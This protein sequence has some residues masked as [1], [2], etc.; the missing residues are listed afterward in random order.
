MAETLLELVNVSKFYTGAQSVV[1]GLNSVSLSFSRGEFVAITGESGSGKTTLASVV[2][3]ILPY[4]SGELFFK[5]KPTSHYGSL[6]WERYRRDNIAY[7]SQNYGILP[8]ASVSKNV[9]SA[10]VI[11]GMKKSD[12]KRAAKDILRRVDLLSLKNR[13]AA[14][15]SS[16][17]KQRL[18]IA[19]A[20]AK[21]APILIADEP[22]GNLD[23]ENSAKIIELLADAAKDRLVILVTHEFDEAKDLATRHI[24]VSEGRIS[25]DTQLKPAPAPGPAPTVEAKGKKAL[26]FYVARLQCSSRPVWTAM[27]S[28]FFAVTAFAVFAFL[29]VFISSIDDT[30]TRI[31]DSSA[32]RNG[33][34]TRIVVLGA[35]SGRLDEDDYRAFLSI[36]HVE[37]VEPWGNAADAQYGY[38]E[39]EG[40]YVSYSEQTVKD[41]ETWEDVQIVVSTTHMYENAPFVRTI[42]I[43][44][45][46]V[47]FLTDG[48]LPENMYEVVSGDKNLKIGDVITIYLVDDKTMNGRGTKYFRSK[49]KVVGLTDY[50]D[51]LFFHDDV[52]RFLRQTYAMTN[53]MDKD[54]GFVY[55]PNNE[56][57]NEVSEDDPDY[58]LFPSPQVADGHFVGSWNTFNSLI[59]EQHFAKSEEDLVPFR[60]RSDD[61]DE[62]AEYREAELTP[63]GEY[64]E[65]EGRMK[66]KDTDYLGSKTLLVDYETFDTLCWQKQDEAGITISDYAYTDRVLEELH[67]MGYSAISVY[68]QG[69]TEVDPEL[70]EDRVQ[71]LRICILAFVVVAV[72]QVV[73]LRAMFSLENESYKLL[74]NIGL[75][76]RTAKRSVWIQVLIFTII[77]ELIGAAG[78]YACQVYGVKRIVDML[79]YL[80]GQYLAVLVAAHFILSAIAAIWIVKALGRQ[81]YPLGSVKHDIELDDGEE[82]AS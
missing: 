67:K 58:S 82:A 45:E 8:G 59:A 61:F 40:L 18:S 34:P 15:L 54:H 76:G 68:R 72:L 63:T 69:S 75:T 25:A 19:R 2:G 14:K 50:G 4:E 78:I 60:F 11:A 48:R 62:N 64:D 35:D 73:V 36:P 39:G 20:L 26:A 3:G 9:E 57:L 38:Y 28:V 80:P 52:G 24:V 44:H 77:G 21:P 17:Q 32:F 74:G 31:Y 16:G 22:T 81:V 23:S 42:P 53:V 70:A 46:G 47:E 29:G 49:Y 43:L 7:I 6:D 13:R 56:L 37:A 30:P 71:T 12:A 27:M 5:G 79:K 55:V 65:E 33:D 1:V 10:L 51:G 41:P 66:F